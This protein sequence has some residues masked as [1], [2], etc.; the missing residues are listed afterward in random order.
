MSFFASIPSQMDS[1]KLY[2]SIYGLR[3]AQ[4]ACKKRLADDLK[5]S[6]F[7]P[8]INAESVFSSSI[9]KSVIYLIIYVDDV[10]V[11]TASEL[12]MTKV[13]TLLSKLYK[14]KD[15]GN[16]EYFASVKT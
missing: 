12:T 16:A 10:L 7:Q 1:L 14:I 3:Q 2:P 13:M 9:D 4:R 6:G 11:V 5:L 8:L 15:L